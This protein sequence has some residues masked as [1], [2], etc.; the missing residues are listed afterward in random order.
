MK[1]RREYKTT[2]SACMAI[3][4]PERKRCLSMSGEGD[5]KLSGRRAKRRGCRVLLAMRPRRTVLPRRKRPL[6]ASCTAVLLAATSLSATALDQSGNIGWMFILAGRQSW[7]EVIFSGRW[8]RAASS[9][10]MICSAVW[11]C[12][13]SVW[14]LG[15]SDQRVAY[16]PYGT[17]R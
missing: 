3:L 15:K 8:K 16:L 13:E 9:A 17:V 1:L 2:S 7:R 11:W 10:S 6:A 14:P 5:L 4:L 12:V